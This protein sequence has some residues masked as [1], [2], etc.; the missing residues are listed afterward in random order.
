MGRCPARLVRKV[1][2][3]RLHHDAGQFRSLGHGRMDEN[4]SVVVIQLFPDGLEGGITK[5]FAAICRKEADA[6]RMQ[7]SHSIP[8]LS[9]TSISIVQAWHRGKET[10][11]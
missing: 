5:V 9:D 3:W 8:D 6:V 10:N 4:D 1:K 2:R 11:T 7:I